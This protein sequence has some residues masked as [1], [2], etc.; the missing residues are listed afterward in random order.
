MNFFASSH[1]CGTVKRNLSKSVFS[2]AAGH[3]ERGFFCGVCIEKWARSFMIMKVETNNRPPMILFPALSPVCS[4][5]S[6]V[7]EKTSTRR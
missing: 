6:D 3:F 4:L 5:V 7:V 1:G 2:E